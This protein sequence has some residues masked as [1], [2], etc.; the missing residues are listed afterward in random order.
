MTRLT[1]AMSLADVRAALNV[2]VD[3]PIAFVVEADEERDRAFGED[4]FDAMIAYL[5][6]VIDNERTLTLNIQW[7]D[8]CEYFDLDA[9][10][11]AADRF[12]ID[13]LNLENWKVIS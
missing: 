8:N 2:E 10:V 3:Q 6:A 11:C 1:G 9:S 4:K 13:L 12:L 5:R 7:D